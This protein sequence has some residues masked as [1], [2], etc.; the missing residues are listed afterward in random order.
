MKRSELYITILLI[1]LDYLMIIMAGFLAY[2][3]R[4]STQI[5][6]IRPAIFDLDFS[7]FMM[8][9]SIV[10]ISWIIIFA[11]MGLYKFEQRKKFIDELYRV[12]TAVSVG[13][14]AVIIFSFAVRELFSSRFIVVAAW[15]LGI[16]LITI[17]RLFVS[18]IQRLL[19]KYGCG[20]H[21]IVLIGGNG[22]CHHLMQTIENNIH[23]GYQVIGV[24]PNLKEDTIDII[25]KLKQRREIN[26]IIHCD[27][28]ID[29]DLVNPVIDY[30]QENNIEF[31]FVPDVFE[32][33]TSNIE[34]KQLAGLPLINLK[35]S[36]IEGWG[37]II[38][39]LFDIVISFLTL[40][41]LVPFFIV[42]AIITKLDKE[43]PGPVFV[44][45]TRQ[46]QKGKFK[47]Y[48]F[49]SMV[50]D[51][52]KM[53]QQLLDLN[54]RKGGP[55]FKMK[56]DPRVTRTGRW[57]RNTSID[58]LPQFLNVLKGDISLVGPRPHEPEEIKNYEKNHLKLL[59]VKPG[60][61]GM[62]QVS[63]RSD[64][65]FAEEAKLDLYYISN[66]SFKLDLQILVK[67]VFVIL[68]RKS[69]A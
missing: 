4:F 65:D 55:L 39:R 26:E 1:P 60:I 22:V 40:L 54:E 19:Y 8:T 21:R 59:T 14:V 62:G 49:R 38:K 42:I 34:V 12:I 51:A 28:K 5:T 56:N 52:H 27:P 58:E 35:L 30:C 13:T 69:A 57:L 64:L 15:F 32:T 29:R 33:Q 53:K 16:I 18:Y 66:W 31:K 45:L 3:I 20:I 68:S 24:L 44:K 23:M 9:L 47:L 11:F 17:T 63:G 48:K 67:T 2:V 61:T 46:N 43:T 41:I 25:S 36:A 10:G 6:S 7:E 50:V 37:K